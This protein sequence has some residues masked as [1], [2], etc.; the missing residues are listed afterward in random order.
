MLYLFTFVLLKNYLATLY[1]RMAGLMSNS[2]EKMWKEAAVA[3]FHEP[4]WHLPGE[5]EEHRDKSNRTADL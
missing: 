5:T 2:L 4:S 1:L 3:Y